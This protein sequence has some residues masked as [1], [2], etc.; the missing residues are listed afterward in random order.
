MNILF[1]TL[2]IR[3]QNPRTCFYITDNYKHE[4]CKGKYNIWCSGIH[5]Q[6][7]GA[8]KF[9]AEEKIEKIVIFG[10]DA[11]YHLE[12]DKELES[13]IELFKTELSLWNGKLDTMSKKKMDEL[14]SLRFLIYRLA[15][16]VYGNSE[17]SDKAYLT[18]EVY[19]KYY[20]KLVQLKP[21]ADSAEKIPVV[22]IPDKIETLPEDENSYQTIIQSENLKALVN[23]LKGNSTDS[24]YLFMD[25]QGGDRTKV[26]VNNALLQLLGNQEKVYFTELKRVVATQ[27]DYRAVFVESKNRIVD[28]TNRYRIVDLVS[29]MNAFFN[30]GKSKQ[31]KLYLENLQ[32]ETDFIIDD[33]IQKLIDS[34]VEM[35]SAITYCRIN[36]SSDEENKNPGNGTVYLKTAVKK[37][38]AAVKS[39]SDAMDTNK[40]NYIGNYF[41][42]L[43]DGIK[44]DLGELLDEGD[45]DIIA[46]IDWCVKKENYVVATAIAEDSLPSYFVRHGILYYAQNAE[47]LETAKLYF[48]YRFLTSESYSTYTFKDINHFFIKTYLGDLNAYPNCKY[49]LYPRLERANSLSTIINNTD[50]DN[51]NY[52]V[53]LYTDTKCSEINPPILSLKED[54]NKYQAEDVLQ[55][56]VLYSFVSFNRNCLA[57]ANNESKVEPETLKD[58]LEQ[59]IELSK[60]YRDK[61]ISD[62][63]Y[64]PAD[65]ISQQAGNEKDLKRIKD[66]WEPEKKSIIIDEIKYELGDS[67]KPYGLMNY[68]IT[69][70][71]NLIKFRGYQY[72]KKFGYKNVYALSPLLIPLIQLYNSFGRKRYLEFDKKEALIRDKEFALFAKLL[73]DYYNKDKSDEE[74]ISYKN[75]TQKQFSADKK[76]DKSSKKEYTE[77]TIDVKFLN[78]FFG[79]SPNNPTQADWIAY[80]DEQKAKYNIKIKKGGTKNEIE[81]NASMLN[82]L[83]DCIGCYR[84]PD[85]KKIICHFLE[86]DFDTLLDALK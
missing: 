42:I 20:E 17:K 70:R 75:F 23:E 16:F 79:S 12:S 74:L 43:I 50:E 49:D 46:L 44:A 38:R 29:A 5:Q 65:T 60:K 62:E 7:P 10:S 71:Q 26:Y 72:P 18:D 52:P 8:K 80:C 1:T 22:F 76:T 6:E 68:Y 2:S 56:L 3:S 53:N 35:D 27:F 81:Q 33:N 58:A 36:E 78:D 21:F 15:D 48:K 82:S 45:I 19:F 37:L 85:W 4:D 61:Y 55:I 14:S 41:D 57:H 51:K 66:L 54:A 32:K 13:D 28:E 63:I 40:S 59:L 9:L 34:I 69:M 11:T 77:I 24:N 67:Q 84:N 73:I 64:L 39:I 86:N 30:H 47:E 31:L 25:M 83:F